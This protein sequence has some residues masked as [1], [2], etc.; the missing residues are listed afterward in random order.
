[1]ELNGSDMGGGFYLV[2]DEPRPRGDSSGG[3]GFGRGNNKRKEQ[4]KEEF[5]QFIAHEKKKLQAVYEHSETFYK[6]IHQ[7]V[8][9]LKKSCSTNNK[10]SLYKG[11]LV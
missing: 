1:M 6:R 5:Q 10:L 11:W 4:L 9:T 7:A 2:V 8:S 3:G